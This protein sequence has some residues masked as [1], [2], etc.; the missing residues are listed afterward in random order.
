MSFIY[1]NGKK[2]LGQ[3]WVTTT[4]ADS[5]LMEWKKEKVNY[6]LLSSF[7]M[8]PKKNN[9]RI[10]NTLHRM[11]QPLQAKYPQKLKLVKTIGDDEASYL[12]E[13]DY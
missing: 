11:L 12:Y 10:I 4:N 3:Y 13:I 2:F 8:D 7:R 6:V 9:G 5:I 1:A